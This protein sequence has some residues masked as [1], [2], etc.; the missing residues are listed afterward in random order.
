MGWNRT[1]RAGA[2]EAS[3]SARGVES[4]AGTNGRRGDSSDPRLRGSCWWPVRFE[5][6]LRRNSG[7]GATRHD[8]TSA[9]TWRGEADL[10]GLM[11]APEHRANFWISW[12]CAVI[13]GRAAMSRTAILPALT[14]RVVERRSTF[15]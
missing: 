6:A 3:P 2:R 13:S 5:T 11:P 12:R 15:N 8:E 7:S 9:R 14:P 1:I 10:L 4:I